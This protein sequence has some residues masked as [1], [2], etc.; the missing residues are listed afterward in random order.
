MFMLERIISRGIIGPELAALSVGPLC[1]IATGGHTHDDPGPRSLRIVRRYALSTDSTSLWAAMWRNI[2]DADGT[3]IVGDIGAT[4]AARI[5]AEGKPVFDANHLFE[6]SAKWLAGWATHHRIRTLNIVGESSFKLSGQTCE[7]LVDVLERFDKPAHRP[8]PAGTCI[9][10]DGW[11]FYSAMLWPTQRAWRWSI[12][13]AQWRP[14]ANWHRIPRLEGFGEAWDTVPPH[15]RQ[16]VAGADE[17]SLDELKA[18][19]EFGKAAD[20]L[21]RAGRWALLRLVARDYAAEG[22]EGAD[23]LR[24]LLQGRQRDILGTFGFPATESTVRILAKIWPGSCNV[25]NLLVIRRLLCEDMAAVKLLRQLPRISTPVLRVLDDPWL[26]GILSPRCVRE[27][28]KDSDDD[29]PTRSASATFAMDAL[30]EAA[31]RTGLHDKVGPIHSVR[32]LN[33]VLLELLAAPDADWPPPPALAG[34]PG[35][36]EP[37]TTVASVVEEGAQMR[38]CLRSYREAMLSGRSLL[39]RVIPDSCFGTERATLELRPT[40]NGQWEVAQ[41]SG[42]R[43]AY[44]AEKTR[45]LVEA[46]RSIAHTNPRASSE[47]LRA[48]YLSKLSLEPLDSEQ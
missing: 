20:D 42:Y 40:R 26:R 13:S 33:E 14:L 6:R 19:S 28:V 11:C 41:I 16:F 2:R 3:L 10:A 38:H 5:E 32:Q 7:L 46:W 30:S 17:I 4:L 12:A 43:N 45:A 18:C 44:V 29:F 23:R 39:F 15:I 31:D 27:I 47:E 48:M 21:I 22:R 34:V 8:V 1:G 36:I 35:L 25:P 37:L 9:F 24:V